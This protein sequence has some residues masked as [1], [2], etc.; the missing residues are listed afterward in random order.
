MNTEPHTN[1]EPRTSRSIR[2]LVV[3]GLVLFLLASAAG[4]FHS[5]PHNL[6]HYGMPVGVAV[7]I[8]YL[9]WYWR[10][11]NDGRSD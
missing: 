6:I 1:N 3:L 2:Q 5:L 10:P 8:A 4:G 11:R 7:L 9:I